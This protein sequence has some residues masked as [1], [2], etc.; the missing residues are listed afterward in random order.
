VPRQK[1]HRHCGNA[2]P[3]GR[4]PVEEC[5]DALLTTPGLSQEQMAPGWL[6]TLLLAMK[7]VVLLTFAGRSKILPQIRKRPFGRLSRVAGKAAPSFPV[8]HQRQQRG[9]LK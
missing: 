5:W 9:A 3:K 1:G 6:R 4:P 8:K 7:D 2:D